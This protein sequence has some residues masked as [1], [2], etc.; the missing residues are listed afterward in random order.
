MHGTQLSRGP[1]VYH[2]QLLNECHFVARQDTRDLVLMNKNKDIP[3]PSPVKADP[4]EPVNH[5]DR[6][7]SLRKAVRE[8]GT[9]P[10]QRL[11]SCLSL[12][13]LLQACLLTVSLFSGINSVFY[14]TPCLSFEISPGRSQEKHRVRS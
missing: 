12:Y 11:C 14:P 3:M 8:L 4:N 5:L 7:M 2:P 6:E 1:E 10:T 9:K 13:G